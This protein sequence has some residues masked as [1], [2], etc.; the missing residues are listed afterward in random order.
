M[1]TAPDPLSQTAICLIRKQLVKKTFTVTDT[2]SS[3]F[4]HLSVMSGVS[5]NDRSRELA[6]NSVAVR[7]GFDESDDE[8]ISISNSFCIHMF[9]HNTPSFQLCQWRFEEMLRE[10]L[11]VKML[12]LGHRISQIDRWDFTGD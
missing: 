11:I 7:S 6:S 10:D 5:S 2:P 12:L 4:I 9:K 3:E 8:V 1:R